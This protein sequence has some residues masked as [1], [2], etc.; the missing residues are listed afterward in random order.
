MDLY[1]PEL[2]RLTTEA[3]LEP[4]NLDTKKAEPFLPLPL[5]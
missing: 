3:I 4:H 1:I 2:N 5:D